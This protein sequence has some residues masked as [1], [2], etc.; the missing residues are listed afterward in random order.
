L[1]D[2]NLQTE[3][4]IPQ[5]VPKEFTDEGVIWPNLFTIDGTIFGAFDVSKDWKTVG[6]GIGHLDVHLPFDADNNGIEK[7][8]L[9]EFFKF[10]RTTRE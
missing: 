9:N 7:R 10:K 2:R 1:F 4:D 8:D 5:M 3:N 6:S